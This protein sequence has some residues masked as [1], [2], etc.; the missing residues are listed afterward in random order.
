MSTGRKAGLRRARTG[1]LVLALTCLGGCPAVEPPVEPDPVDAGLLA[2]QVRLQPAQAAPGE[3]V[4]VTLEGATPAEPSVYAVVGS[5]FVDLDVAFSAGR[6]EATGTFAAPPDLGDHPVRG[7]GQVIDDGQRWELAGG[8][9]LAVS[10]AEPCPPEQLREAGAC[11]PRRLGHPLQRRAWT[12]FGTGQRVMAHPRET[13]VDG[14]LIL[15]CNTDSVAL[16]RTAGLADDPHPSFP[17]AEHLSETMVEDAGVQACENLAWDRDRRL[18]VTTSRGG[19]TADGVFS[20][21][22]T[23]WRLPTDADVGSVNPE[24]LVTWLDESGVEDVVLGA[25]GLLYAAGKPDRLLVLRLGDDGELDLVRQLEVPGLRSAWGLAV[26][27]DRLYLSDAG[28]NAADPARHED[29]G[30]DEPGTVVE[31]HLW[32]FDVAS[33]AEP[34]LLGFWDTPGPARGLAVLPQDVV[35][36]A[37]GPTGVQLVDVADPDTPAS[38][39]VLATP[40]TAQDV[41][42][43][44]G[45]LAVA[46]WDSL[47]LFDASERGVAHFVGASDLSRAPQDFVGLGTWQGV[48]GASFVALDDG[49]FLLSEFDRT[50]LGVIQPGYRAPRLDVPHRWL[51]TAQAGDQAARIPLELRNGGVDALLVDL[52][53]VDEQGAW[54]DEA[55]AEPLRQVLMP[56]ETAVVSA[57]IEG[58]T[59]DGPTPVVRLDSSD[60]E[61]PARLLPVEVN[62]DNYAIGDQT[63][64]FALP[65]INV[66]DEDGCIQQPGCFDTAQVEGPIVLAFFSSW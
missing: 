52:A 31:G 54:S 14:D 51:R 10:Q 23:T 53:V 42:Y 58:A 61:A 21:A 4:T 37:V 28:G 13:I 34:N 49:R 48:F 56:G 3:S 8:T 15:A 45:Y 39:A 29:E 59:P 11:Q 55:P 64:D 22:L 60:P 9:L 44:G 12:M 20:G 38:L 16:Y 18:A 30:H 35:A 2:V 27:G 7:A 36:V 43:D 6:F 50:I 26:D 47:R 40:G 66:C 63:P 17:R 57:Y 1:S 41:A 19:W 32:I 25:D 24:P 62:G 46:D 33:P 65:V 5:G